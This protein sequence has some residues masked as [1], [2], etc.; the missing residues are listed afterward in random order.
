MC[1]WCDRFKPDK[2]NFDQICTVN[3]CAKG[4][5]TEGVDLMDSVLKMV[6]ITAIHTSSWNASMCVT[7]SQGRKV[8]AARC[9]HESQAWN[10]GLFTQD[11]SEPDNFVFKQ[12]CPGNIW[13]ESHVTE[14]AKLLD[15]LL[16]VVRI[17]AECSNYVQ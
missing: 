3:N 10:H 14:G 11:L 2:F 12:S 6:R 8:F 15:S 16:D 4:P 17:E 1:A 7:K 13:A 5:Y 9:T